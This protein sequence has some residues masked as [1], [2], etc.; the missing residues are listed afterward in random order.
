M[1]NTIE[2]MVMVHTTVLCCVIHD[3]S[4]YL[5]HRLY[6]IMASGSSKKQKSYTWN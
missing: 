6:V 1:A 3:V 2:L 4:Q 5:W